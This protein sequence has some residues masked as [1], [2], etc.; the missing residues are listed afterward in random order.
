MRNAIP[1]AGGRAARLQVVAAALLIGLSGAAH[2]DS[3]TTRSS[4]SKATYAGA[5][6]NTDGGQTLDVTSDGSGT[7]VHSA[8]TLQSADTARAGNGRRRSY[9]DSYTEPNYSQPQYSALSTLSGDSEDGDSGPTSVSTE[10]S[11]KRTS[12]TASSDNTLSNETNVTV[13]TP[14]TINNPT[15]VIDATPQQMQ[16]VLSKANAFTMERFGKASRQTWGVAAGAAALASLPQSPY[17]GH[18]MVGM[19][20][21]TANGETAVA[22]GLSYFMSNNQV[23][24]KAGASYNSQGAWSGGLGVGY[25]LP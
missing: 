11:S 19:S 4:E 17:A 25:I 3:E 22:A 24:F 2:A 15:T 16:D 10:S 23:L 7:T 6:S 20:L 9:Y 12:A 14:V 13:S 21:G 8:Q 1:F 5:H 18:S